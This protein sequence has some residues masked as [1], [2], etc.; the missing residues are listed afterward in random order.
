[1]SAPQTAPQPTPAPRYATG[2]TEAWETAGGRLAGY[3]RLLGID[4]FDWQRL[5]ADVAMEHRGGIPHYPTAC[6]QAARQGGKTRALVWPRL[7]ACVCD[8]KAHHAAYLAQT[9]EL[10]RE[11]LLELHEAVRET[12]ALARTLAKVD[13]AN[14]RERLWFRNR[15]SIRILTPSKKGGRG[16]TLD[17]V[18]IDEAG[19]VAPAVYQAVAPTLATRPHA[20][21]WVTSNAGEPDVSELLGRLRERGITSLGD[22]AATICWFEW[23]PP[24]DADPFAHATWELANPSLD[25]PGGPTT[26]SLREAAE[27]MELHQFK[28][29]H[30]NLW[31]P[32]VPPAIFTDEMWDAVCHPHVAVDPSAVHFALAVTRERDRASI[33]AASRLEDGSVA[34]EVIDS[35]DGTGWIYDRLVGLWGDYRAAVVIDQGSQAATFIEPLEAAEVVVDAYTMRGYARACQAFYD[36]VIQERLHHQRDPRLDDAIAAVV[37]RPLGDGW[38]WDQRTDVDI[39]PLVAATLA[40]RRA[41]VTESQDVFIY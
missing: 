16:A 38:A 39:T 17:L 15:S 34:V 33:A 32:R 19:D 8:H 14:G 4:L 2:R 24:D 12:P 11:K 25:R 9:R 40:A 1:M 6:L 27:N 26:A 18:V 22:P 35:R 36:L 31:A 21:M 41:E 20:Q 23:S 29:E 37:K 10:A 28:R 3:A 7:L 13:L 30:L 5:V